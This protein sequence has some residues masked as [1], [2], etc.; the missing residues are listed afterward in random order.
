MGPNRRSPIFTPSAKPDLTR[1]P[2]DLDASATHGLDGG[3]APSILV[4]RPWILISNHRELDPVEAANGLSCRVHAA[5]SQQPETEKKQ[6]AVH[7]DRPLHL[8]TQIPATTFIASSVGVISSAP[9]APTPVACRVGKI[10]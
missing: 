1:L 2:P 7:R 4:P 6:R 9:H 5:R 3:L 10:A 8:G